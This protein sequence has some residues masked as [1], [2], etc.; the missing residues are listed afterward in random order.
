MKTLSPHNANSGRSTTVQR[1][2]FD[3]HHCTLC[4][5]ECG[6]DRVSGKV[7]YCGVPYEL[8]AG[9][10]ALLAWEEPCLTGKK[11]SGAVFFSG[12]NMGCIFCQN[13]AI[14]GSRGNSPGYGAGETANGGMSPHIGKP[15]PASGS[16]TAFPG[17]RITPERLKETFLSLQDQGASTINLVT[18]THYLH[19]IVPALEAARREGLS[20][21]VIYNT[22]AYEKTDS[23]KTLE[24]LVDI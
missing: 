20:I 17:I 23:L 12:C 8:Y 9:R 19:H 7:G 14:S 10:A 16:G 1:T 5:R 21:P 18:P 13:A 24:G 22:S 3:L 2:G 15:A 6:A 11:G 4:P